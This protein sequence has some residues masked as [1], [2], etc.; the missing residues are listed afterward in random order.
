MPDHTRAGHRHPLHDYRSR[1]IYMITI[2]GT[3]RS[4]PFARI[5]H[6]GIPRSLWTPLGHC[7]AD[8]MSEIMGLDKRLQILSSVIM[9]DHF[10]FVI[11]AREPLDRHIGYYISR[12]KGLATSRIR[13]TS[14]TPQLKVFEPDYHD[15]ILRGRNQ[16][17]AMI[18]YVNDN[19][20]RYAIKR[21]NPGY[22]TKVRS[23]AI[24]PDRFEAFGNLFLLDDFDR[25]PVRIHRRWSS[26]E[27]NHARN[28]WR[29]CAIN[30]GTLVSPFIHPVEKEVML[31]AVNSGARIILLTNEH[32]G[33]RFK[34]SGRYFDL[35]ASG[36]LLILR[37]TELPTTT[38]EARITR[39]EALALNDCAFRLCNSR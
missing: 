25:M 24:G 4:E 8:S 16:L 26:D 1:S 10:H 9:P 38:Y 20:R 37:P 2:V 18:N 14:G 3:G 28:D 39:T 19:P 12:I 30:G 33:E 23:L 7:I 17:S 29:L 6:A 32:F 5:T 22:F 27:L 36:R 15:R 21:D 11:F 31:E 34:P 13:L 35:C